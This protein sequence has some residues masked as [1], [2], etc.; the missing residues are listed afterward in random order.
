[1]VSGHVLAALHVVARDRLAACGTE[2]RAADGS[3]KR[4]PLLARI[5][6][7]DFYFSMRVFPATNE[8]SGM[9]RPPGCGKDAQWKSP[10]TDFPTELGNPAQYAG[11]PLSHSLGDGGPPA[12]QEVKEPESVV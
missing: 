6:P 3:V 7:R 10:N 12:G 2:L 8:I 5:F 11:F 1:M 9:P 4:S